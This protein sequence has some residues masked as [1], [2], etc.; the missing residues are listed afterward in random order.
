MGSTA[1]GEWSLLTAFLM[2]K[3][4]LNSLLPGALLKMSGMKKRIRPDSG[5]RI[6]IIYQPP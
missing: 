3:S 1:L 6:P 4:S 2:S 5:K